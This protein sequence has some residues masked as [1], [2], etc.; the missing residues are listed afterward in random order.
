M[1]H[2]RS[3]YKRT[4]D[5][6]II[7]TRNIELGKCKK[8]LA[9][10]IGAHA[11]LKVYIEL[12]ERSCTVTDALDIDRYVFY[13]EEVV[14]GDSWDDKVYIKFKQKGQDLGTRMGNAFQ[15]L[16]NMGYERI[17]IIGTDLPNLSVE[18][19]RNAFLSL[20][21]NDYTIGPSEDGGYYLLGMNK[22]NSSIF[23][24]KTWGGENVLKDTLS[25]MG[26]ER[27]FL[28][29]KLNDVDT[30][31]DLKEHESLMNLCIKNE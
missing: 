10:V 12:T 7:F 2:K 5:A 3:N 28:L 14:R 24:N 9:K 29:K 26:G 15:A 30:Y 6:L 16:F 25:E 1:T 17:V 21:S 18:I 19:I 27:V 20:E 31:E 8:R 13:S 11:A 23:V 4:S 22:M